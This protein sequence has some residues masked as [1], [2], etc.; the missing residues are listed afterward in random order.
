M[1]TSWDLRFGYSATISPPQPGKFR[2]KSVTFYVQGAPAG[3][4]YDEAVYPPPGPG[5][6]DAPFHHGGNS[7]TGNVA[8]GGSIGL[9]TG[10]TTSGATWVTGHASAHTLTIS[11]VL[12]AKDGLAVSITGGAA[13][14]NCDSPVSVE[15]DWAFANYTFSYVDGHTSSHTDCLY[16]TTVS[17][18]HTVGHYTY[19]IGNGGT[20]ASQTRDQSYLCSSSRTVTAEDCAQYPSYIGIGVPGQTK[21]FVREGDGIVLPELE[22]YL[23]EGWWGVQNSRSGRG[24]EWLDGRS[25]GDHG[26]Y[27]CY[28]H[29][30]TSPVHERRDGIWHRWLPPDMNAQ[31]VNGVKTVNNIRSKH[32]DGTWPLDKPIYQRVNGAW[33]Q[34]KGP[35]IP[36]DGS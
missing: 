29:W 3:D 17:D 31:S 19:Y 25:L 10:W 9:G 33:V 36:P 21:Y 1:S 8:G 14:G 12:M 28:A 4:Y 6:H 34:R 27:T 18:S 20:P 35:M 30:M 24:D 13:V 7:L 2:V 16:G 32:D 11:G 22:D 15:W 26:S 5:S 23:F